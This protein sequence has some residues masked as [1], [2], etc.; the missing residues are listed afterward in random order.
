MYTPVVDVKL[1][2]IPS[3]VKVKKNGEPALFP[4]IVRKLMLT[5]VNSVIE[6]PEYQITQVKRGGISYSIKGL[7]TPVKPLWELPPELGGR[8]FTPFWKP[9]EKGL[10]EKQLTQWLTKRIPNA[11]V[12]VK[13]LVTTV[14]AKNAA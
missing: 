3:K 13:E 5:N 7:F 4:N 8:V 12:I 14:P 11:E 10:T 6:P 2:Y 1:Y 9:V